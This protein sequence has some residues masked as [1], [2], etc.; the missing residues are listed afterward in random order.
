M[1]K[2]IAI[3]EGNHQGLVSI[4]A[5]GVISGAAE[6]FGSVLHQIAPDIRYHVERPHFDDFH[7]DK[8]CLDDCDGV[9]F[10]GSAN[11][12]SADDKKAHPARQLMMLA[13][14]KGLPVF[15]S[16]YGMQLAIT[17]LGGRNRAHPSQ[18][19]FAIA[20]DICCTDDG[21]SHP[22]Y[23]GKPAKFDALAMHRDEAFILPQGAQS[24][25]FNNH[26]QHQS[27]VYEKGDVCFWGV[28]YHPE[29]SFAAIANYIERN[30]VDSFSDVLAFTSALG[31]PANKAQ[32]IADFAGY[33][34]ASDTAFI[35][36]YQIDETITNL[37]IHRCE[38]VNFLKLI[39]A[40]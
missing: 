36:R 33:K 11:H 21:V 2:Q 6:Q 31:L 19:E 39:N 9:V 23:A 8:T 30:D 12:W 5:D 32:L 37:A 40:L 26:S 34:G 27:L 35:A 24:L 7:Y 16:C 13:F 22:L 15:G 29:L 4:S 28:Q 38:L 18:T 10:T 1:T 20:R 14:D 25:S 3:I 17:V